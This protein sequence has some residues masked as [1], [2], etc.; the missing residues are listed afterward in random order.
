MNMIRYSIALLCLWLP[1]ALAAPGVAH[2][3]PYTLSGRVVDVADGDTIT[4]LVGIA[5]HRIR[6]ASIDAPET[7]HGSDRPGQPFGEASRKA[8]AE[9]VAGKTITAACYEK[10]RFDRDVC[11]L[12][13]DGTTASRLQVRAGMAWANQQGG[14]KYLRDSAIADLEKEA[15][16]A[17]AGLWSEAKPVKPWVWRVRCWKDGQC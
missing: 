3:E 16:A 2:A 6:L 4:L 7:K 5:R 11:D 15:R 8:L 10:D 1:L 14:G 17:R 12:E 13:V 9:V